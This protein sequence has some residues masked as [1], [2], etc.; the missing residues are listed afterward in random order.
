[1]NIVFDPKKSQSNL[2]KHGVAFEAATIALLDPLVLVI[3]NLNANG[4]ASWL[5]IGTSDFD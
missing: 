3:E 2:K 4:E 5:L 1:M